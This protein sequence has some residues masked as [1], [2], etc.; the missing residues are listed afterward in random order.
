MADLNDII[1]EFLSYLDTVKVYH[2]KTK[3]Y[4][5]HIASDALHGDFSKQVDMFIEVYMKNLNPV[6][7]KIKL[8][9]IDTDDNEIIQSTY[10]LRKYLQELSI[11]D[12]EILNIRDEM[13]ATLNKFLYLCTLS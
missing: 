8:N 3:M 6:I 7:G 13:I 10:K 4:A 11:Q 9:S 1:K 12:S 5:R 2:W